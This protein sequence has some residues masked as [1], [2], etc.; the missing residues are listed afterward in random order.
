[1]RKQA[2][3]EQA[4]ATKEVVMSEDTKLVVMDGGKKR[5]HTRKDLL[6]CV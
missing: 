6:M 1:M 4:G 2:P 3:V 5:K